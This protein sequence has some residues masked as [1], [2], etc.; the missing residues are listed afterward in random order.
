MNNRTWKDHSPS[1]GT[2]LLL[3]DND[4]LAAS[5]QEFLE[6]YSCKIVRAVSVRLAY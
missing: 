5:L 6:L 2:L 4:E 3:E 1:E